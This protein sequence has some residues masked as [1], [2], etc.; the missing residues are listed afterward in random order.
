ML[1]QRLISQL[2]ILTDMAPH[3]QHYAS[4]LGDDN[5]SDW[6]HRNEAWQMQAKPGGNRPI[7]V[8]QSNITGAGSLSQ[9]SG[10]ILLGL[11]F[12]LL[13]D[14]PRVAAGIS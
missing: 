3:V 12:N 6:L 1:F 5:E 7:L 14:T 9:I 4:Q 8:A 2:Q 13:D 10:N 11:V